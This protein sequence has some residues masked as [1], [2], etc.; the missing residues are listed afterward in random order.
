MRGA[1]RVAG[2]AQW[3]VLLTGFR[4]TRLPRE[5]ILTAPQ[6]SHV[7]N[8]KLQTEYDLHLPLHGAPLTRLTTYIFNH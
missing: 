2:E 7:T 4:V 5:L 1:F 6:L 8:S 3:L